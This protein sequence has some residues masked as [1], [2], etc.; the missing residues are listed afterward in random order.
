MISAVRTTEA[1]RG[2]TLLEL[3]VVLAIASLVMGGAIGMLVYSSDE[4]ALREASTEIE[5]MAKRAR[6]SAIL[7]QTPYALEFSEGG[8]RMMPL[9]EAGGEEDAQGSGRRRSGDEAPVGGERLDF[10]LDRGMD[11]HV[12]RWGARGWDHVAKRVVHVWRFDPDGLCEPLGVRLVVG[13]NWIEDEYHPL[14]AAIRDSQ[15]EIR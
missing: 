4:R 5:A 12:R 14:T 6:A 3:V 15:M 10:R 7:N 2:F 13:K 8:V 1:R 9:A 11:L